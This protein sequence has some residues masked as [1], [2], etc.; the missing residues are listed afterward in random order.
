MD[1]CTRFSRYTKTDLQDPDKVAALAPCR[2]C[3]SFEGFPL[4][5]PRERKPVYLM[6]PDFTSGSGK[7]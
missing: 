2:L 6:G 5:Q 3:Q 1:D 7:E 4:Y